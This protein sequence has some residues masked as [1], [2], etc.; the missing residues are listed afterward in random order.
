MRAI[1]IIERLLE[2]M[3]HRCRNCKRPATRFVVQSNDRLPFDLTLVC[4]RHECCPANV[5]AKDLRQAEAIRLAE[6]FREKA[7]A[8]HQEKTRA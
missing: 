1:A 4:D 8:A 7:K 5:Q 3:P 2:A 6:R